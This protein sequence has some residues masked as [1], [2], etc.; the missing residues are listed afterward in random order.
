MK[1]RVHPFIIVGIEIYAVCNIIDRFIYDIPCIIA[2]PAYM[3]GLACLLIGSIKTRNA[4]NNIRC[5]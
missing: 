4:R 2:I 5:M 1:P 3:A